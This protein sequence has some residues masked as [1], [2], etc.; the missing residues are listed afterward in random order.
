MAFVE[1]AQVNDTGTIFRITVYDTTS[2][3]ASIV[4]DISD[5][6]VLRFIFRRPDGTTFERGASLTNDGTD[7][8][9]QYTTV[10]GDLNQSG[11]WLLQAYVETTSGKWR[12]NTA[13]F[14]V[15]ENL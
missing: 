13:C 15:Q 1:Q 5:A 8:L 7:G 12:T 6:V 14:K 9:I 2:T 10:N 3:G 11:S 4:A